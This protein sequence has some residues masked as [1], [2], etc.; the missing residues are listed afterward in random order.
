MIY[1]AGFLEKTNTEPATNPKISLH[2][3]FSEK[4][5]ASLVKNIDSV[6][7]IRDRAILLESNHSFVG[8][9]QYAYLNDKDNNTVR[10]EP[11]FY[12]GLDVN[13]TNSFVQV[14]FTLLP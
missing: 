10:N 11:T 14:R 7:R 9:L 5:S 8:D 13:V 4:L 1:F 3:E 2:I 6:R 12:D